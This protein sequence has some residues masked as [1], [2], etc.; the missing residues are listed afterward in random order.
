MLKVTSTR[1]VFLL[2]CISALSC[3][4]AAAQSGNGW[5]DTAHSCGTGYGACSTQRFG[6]VQ[7][8]TRYR[9]A[10]PTILGAILG[11]ALGNALGHKKRN[12]QVG[13]VVGAVLGAS[14]ARDIARRNH[15]RPERFAAEEGLSDRRI[16]RQRNDAFEQR[17]HASEPIL[18]KRRNYSRY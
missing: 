3:S 10:T 18:L 16:P 1:I 12:K 5:R 11:G 6:D 13:T 9:W 17:L 7:E 14:V 4:N 15:H 2:F 8:N